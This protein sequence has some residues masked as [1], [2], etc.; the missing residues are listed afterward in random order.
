VVWV[1]QWLRSHHS[2]PADIS[3]TERR[4]REVEALSLAEGRERLLELGEKVV[5]DHDQV[6][7]THKT[8]NVVLIS[9]EEWEAYQETQRLFRDKAA[10]KA[11]LQSFEDHDARK[12]GRGKSVDEV[13]SVPESADPIRALRGAV[14]GEGLLD[15]LLEERA[16][17]RQRGS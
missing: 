2:E 3:P 13:F 11:L 12:E 9:M 1:G 6:I 10:L 4:S 5:S 16:R 14:K 15:R 7:L 17:D 8:G